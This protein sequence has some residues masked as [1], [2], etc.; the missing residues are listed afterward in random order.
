MKIKKDFLHQLINKVQSSK[1]RNIT[2][3]SEVKLRECIGSDVPS[4]KRFPF[5]KEHKDER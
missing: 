4:R 3:I 2:Y 5:L 1:L